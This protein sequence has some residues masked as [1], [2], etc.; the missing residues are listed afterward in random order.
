MILIRSTS[1]C[2]SFVLTVKNEPKLDFLDVVCCT[3]NYV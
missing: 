3:E 1:R 2:D